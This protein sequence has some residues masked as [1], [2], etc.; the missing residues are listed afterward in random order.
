[1]CDNCTCNKTEVVTDHNPSVSDNQETVIIDKKLY[2]MLYTSHV[3]L[4]A[5]ECA[6]VDNWEGYGDAMANLDEELSSEEDENIL[7]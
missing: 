5:L 2:L 1:M 6:G 7:D 4:Q 3:I